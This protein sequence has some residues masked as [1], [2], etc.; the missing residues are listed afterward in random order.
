MIQSEIFPS[1]AIREEVFFPS[2]RDGKCFAISAVQA[3]VTAWSFVSPD[4][5]DVTLRSL[6]S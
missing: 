4:G 5:E 3:M 2:D 1:S 6:A